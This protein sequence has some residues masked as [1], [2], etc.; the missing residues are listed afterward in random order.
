[1]TAGF[2]FIGLRLHYDV[3]IPNFHQQARPASRRQPGSRHRWRRGPVRCLGDVGSPGSTPIPRDQNRGIKTRAQRRAD[4]NVINGSRTFISERAECRRDDRL[5]RNG[6][7]ADRRAG[8]SVF[9]VNAHSCANAFC[10]RSAS[11]TWTRRSS[12]STFEVPAAN[13][14]G[15]RA[16]LWRSSP[17]ASRRSGSVSPWAKSR[18]PNPPLDLTAED[19]QG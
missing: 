13:L 2:A 16:T 15:M 11:P 18:W 3:V 8:L 9:V 10:R 4:V 7:E 19:M 14:L 6:H 1:M 12:S 5:A 17:R